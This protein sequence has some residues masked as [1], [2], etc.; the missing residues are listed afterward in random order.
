MAQRM[1]RIM[2]IEFPLE[3]IMHAHRRRVQGESAGAFQWQF[4]LQAY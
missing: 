1:G 2:T 4:G 3:A